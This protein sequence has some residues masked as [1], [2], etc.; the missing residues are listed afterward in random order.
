M[1]AGRNRR[2]KNL[3]GN[4]VMKKCSVRVDPIRL[5]DGIPLVKEKNEYLTGE[6][7]I[8][9]CQIHPSKDI[10]LDQKTCSRLA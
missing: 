7:R 4:V 6:V 2:G 9:V 5:V 1:K 8:F 10:H 3:S